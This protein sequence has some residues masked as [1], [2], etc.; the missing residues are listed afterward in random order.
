MRRPKRMRCACQEGKKQGEDAA[1]QDSA[2]YVHTIVLLHSTPHSLLLRCYTANDVLPVMIVSTP[3]SKD[4]QFSTNLSYA[5]LHSL[6]FFFLVYALKPAC[7][8]CKGGRVLP[9][10][11]MNKGLNSYMSAVNALMCN[12]NTINYWIL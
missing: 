7:F 12:T 4:Q 6:G 2:R 5:I 11:G 1:V 8:G 9:M 10:H 3:S